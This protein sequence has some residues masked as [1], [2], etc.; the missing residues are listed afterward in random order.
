M[1]NKKFIVPVLVVLAAGLAY[2]ERGRIAS[3]SRSAAV[4][5]AKAATPAQSVAI[6]AEGRIVT[7][8]GAEVVVGTDTGGTLK[9][10]KVAER[11]RVKKGDLIAQID[12]STEW[13]ALEEA[14]AR[15]RE[16]EVDIRFFDDETNKTQ[17]L[18]ASNVLPKDSLDRSAHEQDAARA[19]RETA[20]AQVA[21]LGAVAA[22][23]RIVAPFD[24]VVTE[25]HAEQGETVP[26]GAKIVT[27][28]DLSRVRVEAEVDEYDAGRIALGQQATIAA[29]GYP[30]T[31][32]G[33]VEEIPDTVVGRRL[34]PGDPGRPTDTRVLLVKIALAGE[35][36]L[37]L[38]QRVQIEIKR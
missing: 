8:P 22:K 6:R 28:A 1:E 38:G 29:E 19:R 13:A 2:V 16:A 7:Y 20:A 4:A 12:A 31:W 10:L 11:T 25:R 33:K 24:G 18:F 9:A 30:D 17:R 21:R 32:S 15:L 35:T 26:P 37:K 5:E 34:K 3:F 14:R 36:P 23:S 27:I